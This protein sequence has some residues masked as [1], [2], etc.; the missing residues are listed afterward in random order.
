MILIHA[1]EMS[2]LL[3]ELFS[4]LHFKSPPLLAFA[5][6]ALCR[7]KLLPSQAP[8]SQVCETR[9]GCLLLSLGLVSISRH[10]ILSFIVLTV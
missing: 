10:E 8:F 5:S 1:A 6:A 2:S 7:L 9:S 3:R 4:R